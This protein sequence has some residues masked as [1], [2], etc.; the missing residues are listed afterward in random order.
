MVIG[1]GMLAKAFC[2]YEQDE[3]IILFASGVSNSKET[4]EEEFLKELNLLKKCL[5][6]FPNKKI[7]YF[8]TCSIYDNY[9]SDTK[10]VIHKKNIEKFIIDNFNLYYIFRLPIVVGETKN[11]NTLFNFFKNSLKKNE[12]I[13]IQKDAYRYL[14]DVNDLVCVIS[15][16]LANNSN[17]SI[18]MNICYDNKISVFN[19]VDLMKKEIKSNSKVNLINGGSNYDVNNF[20]F[21]NN[22][23]KKEDLE[24][25]N[26][27]L[28]RKYIK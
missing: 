18:I 15:N 23:D 10:Y 25:Y 24:K 20:D 5:V 16:I 4:K 9:L 21:L 17:K 19:L 2:F 22:I 6:D 3:N 8:S 12:P 7:I 13:K 28:I 11:E 27:K 1:K 14:I 26:L